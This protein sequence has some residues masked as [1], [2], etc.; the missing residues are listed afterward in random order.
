MKKKIAGLASAVVVMGAVSSCGEK[1][2]EGLIYQCDEYSVFSDSVVQGDYTAV[3][4]SPL[5][6]RTN[7][8][9]PELSGAS[10]KVEFRFSLNSRDNEL[11]LGRAHTALIGDEA[12]DNRVY[13][14]GVVSADEPVDADGETLPVDSRWTVRVDMRPVLRSF[15]EYGYYATA[16]G[17]T[18]YS[19]DFKGIWIAGSVDPLSWDFENLYGKDD[20]RLTDRGDGIYEV[21]L[22]V[23]P[24]TDRPADPTGWKIDAPNAAYP[25][26]ESPQKLLTAVYNLGIAD[27]VSNIRPDST[28]RAG[29]EWDGVWT[30]DVAYSIYLSLAYLDPQLSM[31]S[32]RAKVKNGHI[33]QDTGTGG[34]WPVSSD[35]VVWGLAAWEI[36]LVTGDKE[37]LTESYE[38]LHNTL[39]AD[40]KV[41]YDTRFNLMHGEQSYLDWRE[42]TY[43]KWMQPA[44]IY[45]SMCLGTNVVFARACEIVGLMRDELNRL[46]DEFEKC[47]DD[48]PIIAAGD[49]IKRS[50]NNRLWIPSAGYYSGY[51]Y[52][53]VYPIQSQATDNLGQALSVIFDVATPEMAQSLVSKT[54]VVPFG[55]PS[56]YPQQPDIKPYH[57]DAVWPF[58]QAYWNLA[59]AK[60]GNMKALTAGLAAIYR[61]AAMFATN[62]E[63]YVA[64]NGDYRGTAVNS[65]SQLWSCSGNVAMVFRV[66]AG[67]TF[68]S[69][70]IL[71]NPVVPPTIPGEK[72]VTGFKYR[73]AV[74]DITVNGT[75][76]E[77][78][79]F[80]I[81]GKE[82]DGPRVF[83]ADMSGHHSVEITLSGKAAANDEKMNLTVQQWMPSTP[84]M[85]W[86]GATD[87]VIDNYSDGNV[88]QRYINGVREDDIQG[89][90]FAVPAS[91]KFTAINVVPVDKEN[92]AGFSPRTHQYIPAGSLIMVQAEDFGRPGTKFIADPKKAA[93]FVE[94]TRN[95]FDFTVT[96]PEAGEYFIDVRYANGAGPIN[97]ENKCA[98]RSLLVGGEFAGPIVM[99]QR[100]IGEWLSTGYSNMLTVRLEKGVNHLSIAY[101]P[102]NENMNGEFNTALIDYIRIIKK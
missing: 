98:L 94:L 52:G 95:P 71:F 51:L 88:Y 89:D 28:F 63:L 67:M 84:V 18:I 6:L 37:W 17:D 3:A 15:K 26:F 91:G 23:N 46:G 85:T 48:S 56:V 86:T 83:P 1:R 70:G 102:F 22:T 12:S 45:E 80:M 90:E 24:A 69:E 29:K 97:T 53:G 38:I 2:S 19:D 55:T 50:V 16:T 58:V 77:V 20:R 21:T 35:R 11:P 99:P 27:I 41:C 42:Q 34:A 81:D 73:D 7:Y 78:S 32:L 30:R 43:P 31:N 59:A 87:A 25:Q 9:S 76:P 74:I 57:N 60:A 64:S 100:G 65:D 14:F 40:L 92:L 68:T 36:Y 75:G 66:Y 79:R 47:P 49:E 62:K 44:D 101:L 39:Q 61:A 10:S 5:E 8:R 93:R 4:V 72:K 54:P 96:A 82:V 13:S 33:I